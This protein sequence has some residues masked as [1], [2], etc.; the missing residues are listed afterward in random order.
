MAVKVI[1]GRNF[2][3][4]RPPQVRFRAK[5]TMRDYRNADSPPSS[6]RTRAFHRLAVRQ[7]EL[8]SET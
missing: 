7:H 5:V 8:P 1:P 4:F 3:V 2:P 6:Q